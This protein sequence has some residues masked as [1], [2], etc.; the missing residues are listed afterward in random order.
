M[1]YSRYVGTGLAEK[2]KSL[3]RRRQSSSAFAKSRQPIPL[4]E[5]KTLILHEKQRPM[6]L[7][8]QKIHC[9]SVSAENLNAIDFQV[10][11][12]YSL[13]CMKQ[14]RD[15]ENENFELGKDEMDPIDSK[16]RRVINKYTSYWP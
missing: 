3:S 13:P 9:I 10:S 7:T 6:F 14:N 11:K 1:S 15:H 4:A 2:K 8:I 5:M 12:S 16:E